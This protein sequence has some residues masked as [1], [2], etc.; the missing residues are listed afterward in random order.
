[1]VR[2]IIADDEVIVRE[3]L[4]DTIDWKELGVEVVACVSDGLALYQEAVQLRAEIILSDIRMPKM[5]GLQAIE[6]IR[7]ELPGCVFILFTA[8]EEFQLAKKAID[9]GVMAYLTKPVSRREV[10]EKVRQ[11]VES[12]SGSGTRGSYVE[13][14]EQYVRDHLSEGVTLQTMAEDMQ[15]HPA[16]LSRYFKE[17]T[18]M[19]F[20]LFH[21]R[22]RMERA[23]ELLRD[24]QL[25]VYEI[26]ERVGYQNP[27]HFAV[28]FRE[29]TGMSPGEYRMGKDRD[30]EEAEGHGRA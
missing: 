26:A 2:L 11:A 20:H 5:D 21:R 19:N 17:K 14:M 15:M 13:R 30:S 4:R 1:M 22:V 24:T 16:Y 9:L 7:R 8:Y 29:E 28:A 3:G 23:K 18:G 25:K 27:Q 6:K 12:L 10:R